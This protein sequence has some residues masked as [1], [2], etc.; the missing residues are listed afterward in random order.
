M[1]DAP[2]Q[3][4]DRCGDILVPDVAD[5]TD[6]LLLQGRDAQRIDGRGG[7][8][9]PDEDAT[10]APPRDTQ[11][12]G[13]HARG[14]GGIDA[15][16][17]AAPAGE[18]V[19]PARY[20]RR[21]GPGRHPPR[22]SRPA[23]V[24]RAVDRG[25]PRSRRRLHA[26]RPGPRSRSCRRRTPPPTRPT[27]GDRG[28]SPGPRRS[29]ARPGRRWP[30]RRMDPRGGSSAPGPRPAPPVRHPRRGRARHTRGTR[31]PHAGHTTSTCRTTGSGRPP[32]GCPAAGPSPPPPPPPRAR[33]SRGPSRWGPGHRS[34]DAVRRPG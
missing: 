18:G 13:H 16:I 32:R 1:Q 12:L 20:R 30:D 11:G 29:M 19:D 3:Q 9:Q 5:D 23:P 17:R 24:V 27:G 2:L 25:P 6:E 15:H 14:P 10:A 4:P 22:A 26:P 31:R 34:A 8:G 21:R 33:R 28:A 7:R